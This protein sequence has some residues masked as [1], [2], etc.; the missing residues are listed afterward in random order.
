MAQLTLSLLARRLAATGAAVT[1]T[2]TV[3]TSLTVFGKLAVGYAWASG[4]FLIIT[5]TPARAQVVVCLFN[6]IGCFL[7]WGRCSGAFVAPFMCYEPACTHVGKMVQL[8]PGVSACMWRWVPKS[9]YLGKMLRRL[10]GILAWILMGK[11]WPGYGKGCLSMSLGLC[12]SYWCC[13]LLSPCGT[14]TTLNCPF[15]WTA[16]WRAGKFPRRSCVGTTAVG[17][18]LQVSK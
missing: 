18:S 13:S 16:V 5:M 2:A 12:T 15:G 9:R 17:C 10:Y 8:L 14:K 6:F 3:M 11:G 1:G 7:A 4:L